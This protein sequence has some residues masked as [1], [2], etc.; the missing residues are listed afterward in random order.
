M[1][2]FLP[3]GLDDMKVGRWPVV[4]IAL[5]IGC[6]LVFLATDQESATALEWALDPSQG[7]MQVGWIAYMF[8]HADWMHLLGNLLFLYVAAPYVEDAWGVGRFVLLYFV[9]GIMAGLGQVF[10]DPSST[11]PVIGASGAIAACMGAFCVQFPRRKVRV[12]WFFLR[13]A[14]TFF[15]PVWLWG[16]FWFS[17]ELFYLL[18][19]PDSGGVAFGAHLGGF[20]F[21]AVMAVAVIKLQGDPFELRYGRPPPAPPAPA[22]VPPSSP[23]IPA[24]IPVLGSTVSAT[25]RPPRAEV[26]TQPQ[27]ETLPSAPRPF[28]TKPR[29]PG[30]R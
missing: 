25:T 11:I 23:P 22:P 19:F 27:P 28:P 12:F 15:V 16:G 24:A 26:R 29:L 5:A 9:G 7:A 6:L 18:V 17:R 13:F 1:F 10:L 20:A 2:A 21:G 8:L 4:S 14:G 30:E 3:I